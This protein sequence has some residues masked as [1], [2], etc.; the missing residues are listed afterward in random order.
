M[1]YKNIH[2]ATGRERSLEALSMDE[3]HF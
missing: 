3:I 2:P 1:A